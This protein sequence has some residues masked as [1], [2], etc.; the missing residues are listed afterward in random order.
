MKA[1]LILVWFFFLPLTGYCQIITTIAGTGTEGYTG[2]NGPA[3]AA[4][5]DGL[6][7]IGCDRAGNIY[8]TDGL[9][10]VLRKIDATGI[11][12]TIAGIDSGYS[13]DGGPS[14][15]A[16]LNNPAGIAVDGAGNIFIA[17]ESNNVVR[18]IDASG[19]ISTYAGSG[20]GGYSGDGGIATNA[21]LVWPAGVALDGL[22]NLFIA[23]IGNSVVR[24]VSTS[25]IITTV[26]GNG[27]AGPGNDG[28]AAISS[29]LDNP[30]AVAIDKAGNIYIADNN[31]Y[32]VRKVDSSGIITTV[33]GS[34]IRGFGGDNGP[35][36]LAK[37]N[38]VAGLA[39]DDLDNLYISDPVNG[40]IRK[41][42]NTG[43]ITTYAG[44]GTHGLGD[45]GPANKCELNYPAGIVLNKAGDLYIADLSNYR[46][47][48]IKS[49]LFTN[50]EKNIASNLKIDP[51]PL[52]E[53]AT[54]IFNN[55][56]GRN[57]ELTIYNAQ[58]QVV[59]HI[60]NITSDRI[61]I[62][63]NGLPSGFYYYRLRNTSN[64]VYNGKF[65]IS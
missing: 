23:E 46:V 25:G 49:T 65:I 64:I 50:D 35:A 17:D 53:Y 47:R 39:I 58:S 28:I 36:T 32:R 55:P 19:I 21:E 31:S 15:L 9:H 26:A 61:R 3:I 57:F 24:K 8:I 12:T 11:I 6:W 10:D 38:L 62:E 41:V 40:R 54:L 33:A 16:K 48:F 29:A 60:D 18:K 1:S 45:G 59:Q 13:G 7:G 42:D 43:I 51:N 5:V 4:E 52:T 56:D 22:G 37:I 44:G 63:R 27:I 14:T 2:D 20:S 34:E 30:D